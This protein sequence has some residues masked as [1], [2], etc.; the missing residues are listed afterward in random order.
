M[1][2]LEQSWST[3]NLQPGKALTYWRATPSAYRLNTAN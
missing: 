2:M 1:A 3:E